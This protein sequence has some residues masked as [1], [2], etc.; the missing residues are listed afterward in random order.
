V[1]HS[2]CLSL[3]FIASWHFHVGRFL[4]SFKLTVTLFWLH[5]LHQDQ[6]RMIQLHKLQ[7]T[8]NACDTVHLP[9]IT[10]PR[11][12]HDGWKR[13]DDSVSSYR[14]VRQKDEMVWKEN[15]IIQVSACSPSVFVSI[16]LSTNRYV[17]E[18]LNL[19]PVNAWVDMSE[20]RDYKVTPYCAHGVLH[21]WL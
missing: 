21:L 18:N 16:Y 20:V 11:C 8:A 13:K 3:T 19:N 6:S 12:Q 14:S 7:D 15:I 5:M 17:S 9:Y 2:L 1:T 10:V 4:S